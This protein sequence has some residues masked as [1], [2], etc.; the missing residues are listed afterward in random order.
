MNGGKNENGHR[1]RDLKYQWAIGTLDHFG[2]AMYSK[3]PKA[4]GELVV[5]GYDADANYVS[6]SIQPSQD[7]V[8]IEDNGEGMDEQDIREGYMFIGSAQKRAV[9]HTPIYHRLPI[10]NKG[11]GKLAGFGIAKRIEVRTV[12]NGKALEFYQDRDELAKAEKMGKLKEAVLDR[13]SMPLREFDAKG[14]TSGTTVTLRKLRPECGKIDVDKVMAHLAQELPLG[15]D[16]KVIVNS[17]PCEPKYIPALRKIPINYK[18]PVC[19]H[20]V[21]E[22]IVAKKM[23]GKPGV[24]T[25]VRG[26]VVGEPSL[27]GLSTTA[28]R[29]HIGDLIAGSVEVA[30]FDPGR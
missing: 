18:D 27:F 30:S 6:V 21:G 16:F 26:R 11:I 8:T 23:L 9:S 14:E 17:R 28:F 5:N 29:Y 22:I 1:L 19:G 4:I 10:G 2:L 13:A 3:Y 24:F 20:I 25:T 7:K 12:K 15:K